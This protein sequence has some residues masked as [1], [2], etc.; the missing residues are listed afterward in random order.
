MYVYLINY[1]V[2]I[3]NHM[4]IILFSCYIIIL[5]TTEIIRHSNN[6]YIYSYSLYS[7]AGKRILMIIIMP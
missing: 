2:G 6:I 1:W 4:V 7:E 5:F 3:R